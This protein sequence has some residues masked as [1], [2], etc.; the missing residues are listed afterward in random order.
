M[1]KHTVLGRSN[2]KSQ[3][4]NICVKE[5]K[6]KSVTFTKG[7]KHFSKINGGRVTFLWRI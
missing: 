3:S 4:K 2:L 1:E 6:G 5:M 7:K